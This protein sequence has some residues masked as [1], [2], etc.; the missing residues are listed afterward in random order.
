MNFN[1]KLVI[2]LLVFV[3]TKFITT[4]FT[5]ASWKLEDWFM[6]FNSIINVLLIVCATCLLYRTVRLV[7]HNRIELDRIL[8][9]GKW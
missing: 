9:E 3:I 5:F 4:Y 6:H 7:C 2:A 1:K 8:S